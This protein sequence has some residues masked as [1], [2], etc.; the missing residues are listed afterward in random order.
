MATSRRKLRSSRVVLELQTIEQGGFY[1]LIA[2]I[3]DTSYTREVSIKTLPAGFT[4]SAQEKALEVR[5]A[6]ATKT[7]TW[8]W[9]CFLS[10]AFQQIKLLLKGFKN[11]LKKLLSRSTFDENLSFS[12]CSA[13]AALDRGLWI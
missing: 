8:T 9:K 6:L 13:F 12:G 11:A 3:L 4:L 5:D 1:R 2:R 10:S 7:T